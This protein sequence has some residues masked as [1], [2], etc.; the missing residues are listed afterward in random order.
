MY[1]L[2]GYGNIRTG[3]FEVAYPS[4]WKQIQEFN[5]YEAFV[6]F[7]HPASKYSGPATVA[8]LARDLV[9]TNYPP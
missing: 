6:T 3:I 7:M 1:V 8:I 2:E 4:G 5:Y 9:S